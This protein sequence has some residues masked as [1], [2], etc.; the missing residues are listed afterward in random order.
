MAIHSESPSY[1]MASSNGNIFHV[2]AICEGNPPVTDGF[3]S[4]RPVT[5][6]FHVFFDLRLN[7]QL[8]KQ[9]RRRW[10]E[11]PLRPLWRHCND[12]SVERLSNLK[13]WNYCHRSQEPMSWKKNLLSLILALLCFVLTWFWPV[14]SK[15]YSNRHQRKYQSSSSLAICEGISQRAVA[16]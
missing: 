5:R 9:S 6:S 10:L 2:L 12:L 3:P 1:M 8:S 16:I 7:K 14:C 15:V 13:F 4:Q 11:S